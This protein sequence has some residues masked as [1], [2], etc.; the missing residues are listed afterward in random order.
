MKRFRGS[1]ESRFRLYWCEQL[2]ASSLEERSSAVDGNRDVYYDTRQHI[3][4][5]D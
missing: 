3:D 2:G 5:C 1:Q 4:L